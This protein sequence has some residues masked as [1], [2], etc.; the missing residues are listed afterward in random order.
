[1]IALRLELRNRVRILVGLADCLLEDRRV[2]GDPFQTVAL[3]HV[4]QF[5]LGDQAPLEIVQPGG[6]SAGF[7]LFEWVH[8]S[9]FASA[10]CCFAA[11][12]TFSGVKPNFFSR[13]LSG[14]EEPNV[15]M[16]I[17]APVIPT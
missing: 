11:S 9:S 16:P 12:N 17:L 6:L 14:A 10:S 1:V 2:R 15:C 13:S 8:G 3:N 5:T 4:T 7:E